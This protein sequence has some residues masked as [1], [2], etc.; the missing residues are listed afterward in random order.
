M[1]QARGPRVAD[2]GPWAVLPGKQQPE[3]WPAGRAPRIAVRDPR[4][5]GKGAS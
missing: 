1:P 5:K 4:A 3:G 2:R